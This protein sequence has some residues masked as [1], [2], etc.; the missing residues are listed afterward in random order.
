VHGKRRREKRR[1]KTQKTKIKSPVTGGIFSEKVSLKP[2]NQKKKNEKLN[3]SPPIGRE[4][5]EK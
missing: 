3:G 2:T 1:K 5:K 4:L